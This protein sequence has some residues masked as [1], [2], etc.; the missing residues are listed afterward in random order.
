VTYLF[1]VNVKAAATVSV[2]EL[3][4]STDAKLRYYEA[5]TTSTIVTFDSTT[6]LAIPTCEELDFRYYTITPVLANGWSFVGEINKW[7][8]ASK[9]RFSGLTSSDA[10]IRVKATGVSGERV[11][12]A[13]INTGNTVV[14]GV[15]TVGNTN[16]VEAVVDLATQTVSCY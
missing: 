14:S 8:S 16:T 2:T 13:F 10:E 1:A 12:V 11:T 9:R 7:V 3:G 5:N 15:C 6:P 4:Y